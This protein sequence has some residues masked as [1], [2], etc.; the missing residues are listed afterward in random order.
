[1]TAEV[2]AVPAYGDVFLNPRSDLQHT[3][4]SESLVAT[5]PLSDCTTTVLKFDPHPTALLNLRI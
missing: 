5:A 3:V 2:T 1:M 4:S